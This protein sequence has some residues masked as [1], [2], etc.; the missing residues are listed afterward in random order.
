MT[1]STDLHETGSVRCRD[2]LA[3]VRYVVNYEHTPSICTLF[4][5]ET[6]SSLLSLKNI[7]TVFTFPPLCRR[8]WSGT[9]PCCY[10]TRSTQ[11]N[12]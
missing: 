3:T 12:L 1:L 2:A 8:Y 9:Q 4:I 10:T 6:D 5:N 7:V 11:R